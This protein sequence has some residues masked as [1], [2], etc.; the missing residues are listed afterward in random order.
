MILFHIINNIDTGLIALESTILP[1]YTASNTDSARKNTV[2]KSF[3]VCPEDNVLKRFIFTHCSD[4]G[5]CKGD[6][7][8]RL[9][10]SVGNQIAS[11]DDS[12]GLCSRITHTFTGAC[13][14]YT[15]KQGCYSSGT[16]TATTS[17]IGKCNTVR[18]NIA[19]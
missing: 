9:Y 5:Y 3:I 2:G 15:L 1:T 17:I 10:D 4:G 7:Y 14:I 8:L 13:Q 19:E 6:S 16:C 12:C 11:N 18:C